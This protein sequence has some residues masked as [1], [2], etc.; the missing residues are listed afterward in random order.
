MS[1]I[2]QAQHDSFPLI[3]PFRI[4]RGTKIVADVVTVT[5]SDGDRVGRG[6]GVPYP[7]YGET[8]EGTIAAIEQVRSLI[9]QGAGRID[10][11]DALPAGAARNAVD[12]ALWDLEARKA[13]RDLADM[14]GNP[15][16]ARLASALTIVIDIYEFRRL[17]RRKFKIVSHYASPGLE[18]LF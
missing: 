5:I 3:R 12:C 15:T 8:I 2:L 11:L 17:P 4:A 18:L 14:I 16:P 10:L 7:R 9:E 13:G 1:I 6:E